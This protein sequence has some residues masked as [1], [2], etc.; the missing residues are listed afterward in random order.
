MRI[1]GAMIASRT[2]PL[3]VHSPASYRI[4]VPGH[5][6]ADWSERIGG[7]TITR[8]GRSTG[9]PTTEMVGRVADQAALLGVLEQLY[10]L[11]VPLL[12]VECLDKQ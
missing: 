5:L 10:A 9:R 12:R 8:H 6:S 11:G 2:C 3:A 4:L 1:V 7:M